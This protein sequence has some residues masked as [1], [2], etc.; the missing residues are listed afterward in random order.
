MAQVVVGMATP[1]G[2]QMST[3]WSKWHEFEQRDRKHPQLLAEPPVTFDELV[4][5]ARPGLGA[6]LNEEHWKDEWDRAQQGLNVLRDVLREAR[7]D[8]IVAI[9]DDQHEHLLD[10]N[11]PQFCIYWGD[12][13]TSV[14]RRR[15]ADRKDWQVSTDG[16]GH[17]V[18]TSYPAAPELAKHTIQS[19]KRQG[20][21]VAVSNQLKD[22]VGLGHAFTFLYKL[23]PDQPLPLLP[24]M[25]NCFYPPNQP[26][27]ARCYAFGQALRQAIATWDSDQRVA[28]I[29]SGGLS[30]V[31]VDEEIDQL[32][33]E[34]IRQKDV[35]LFAE[36]PEER[37]IRGTSENRNWIIV[38]GAM[39]AEEFT[40]VDYIPAYRNT[41]AMGH[42]LALAY[43][44]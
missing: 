4:A 22:N 42:G 2:P 23:T 27:P 21:D 15:T 12:E 43:W 34:A 24:V 19:M 26:L 38:A 31:V 33:L 9:G 7:P 16:P 41:A 28:I 20:F 14:D 25:V 8:V 1:H 3:H 44:K 35:E 13:L 11:M 40:L 10:D 39:E 17:E 32:T 36:L 30:H 29:G 37:L 5:R 18:R 6:V